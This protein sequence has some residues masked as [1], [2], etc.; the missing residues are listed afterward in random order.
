MRFRVRWRTYNNCYTPTWDM[1][2]RNFIYKAW[3]KNCY[4]TSGTTAPQIWLILS[5]WRGVEFRS[6]MSSG[7]TTMPTIYTIRQLPPIPDVRVYMLAHQSAVLQW[8]KE[9][10]RGFFATACGVREESNCSWKSIH[11]HS[12]TQCIGYSDVVWW[13][14][15]S[16]HT[17]IFHVLPLPSPH[18]VPPMNIS[19]G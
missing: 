16:M 3:P 9:P 14:L 6:T 8:M 12:L 13:K 10:W 5:Q 17:Y 18:F 4:I 15:P 2:N 11:T 7:L 1:H 19:I